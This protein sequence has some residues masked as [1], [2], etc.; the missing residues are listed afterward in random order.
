MEREMQND[1][2]YSFDYNRFGD[3]ALALEAHK[4]WHEPNGTERSDFILLDL[5]ESD[6][7]GQTIERFEAEV[8]RLTV[9]QQTAGLETAMNEAEK[10]AVAN[11]LLDGERADPRLFTQGPP[12]PFTT[13]RE[14]EIDVAEID[15]EPAI[16]V[17]IQPDVPDYPTMY[18]EFAAEAAREREANAALEGSAWFEATFEKAEM[19]LLPSVND[20]VNYAVGVQAVDPWTLDLVV[21]K[22]WK[23]PD[24]RLGVDSLTINSYDAEDGREQGEHER[25]QL[26]EVF[27]ER[28]LEAMMHKAEL[29]AVQNEW[30]A[31]DRADT[32]LFTQG[33][34]DRFETLAQQLVDEINPYWNTD[35][36]KIEDPA[37][38]PEVENPY[39]RLDPIP[40][41][42]P[43]GEPLGHALHMVVYPGV[44]RDPDAVG[45]PTM[46]A[47]EPFQMLEMAHFETPEA[48]DKFGKEF[49][50]YLIP[51]L[52]DGP[53][54]AVEVARLEGL[55]AEW[56]TLEGDVLKAYQ[57]AELTLTRDP[58]DWH[59]YNPNAERDARISAEGLY[60][61]PVHQSIPS[62]ESQQ[63]VAVPDIDF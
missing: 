12:D 43:D 56:K 23:E 25:A 51:G 59:P 41:N 42:D 50:G 38:L 29:A 21:E 10:M 4:A 58:A 14:R 37:P 8:E 49:N 30:L 45:S 17:S 44:E 15:T 47:D 36:E 19:E 9:M 52:L 54:L 27:D 40:V 48:V 34:P 6:S 7:S 24:G 53:E 11:G 62:D 57:N 13:L 22:Y 2:T 3:D 60:Y 35:G 61:D 63:D 31:G 32:R 1:V 39:W 20:T 5:H 18:R 16:P 26:M 28:G 33:P 55:P 46:A